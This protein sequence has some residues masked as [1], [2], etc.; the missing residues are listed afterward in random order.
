VARRSVCGVRAWRSVGWSGEPLEKGMCSFE[1]T[2]P[3]AEEKALRRES[4]P[5][6]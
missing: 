3:V 5:A 6:E 2:T 1:V 4:V